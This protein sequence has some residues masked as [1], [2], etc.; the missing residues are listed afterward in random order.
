ME[1]HLGQLD[2][3]LANGR[4]DVMMPDGKVLR[5]G[6][7]ENARRHRYGILSALGRVPPQKV[8][9]HSAAG[10]RCEGDVAWHAPEAEA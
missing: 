1:E 9:V 10:W 8:R 6:S 7:I 3:M 5:F 2:A 4:L